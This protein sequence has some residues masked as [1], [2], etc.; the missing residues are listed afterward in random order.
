[1]TVKCEKCGA[2]VELLDGAKSA[3]CEKCGAEV[4]VKEEAAA[5]ATEEKKEEAAEATAEATEEKKEEA[6]EK[7]PLTPKEKAIKYSI[8]VVE[9]AVIL[10]ALIWG[11]PRVSVRLHQ[12]RMDSIG[13]P[14]AGDNNRQLLE[15]K[16]VDAETVV[17]PGCFT[18]IGK[19][20]FIDCKK[21]KSITIP[22]TVKEI[23]LKAFENIETLE[24][25]KISGGAGAYSLLNF[26]TYLVLGKDSTAAVIEKEAFSGCKKLKSIDLPE[27]LTSIGQS[28]FADCKALKEIKLPNTVTNIAPQAF[29]RSGLKKVTIPDSVQ[30][31]GTMAFKY[32]D[33][34]EISVPKKFTDAQITAWGIDP[35]KCKIVKR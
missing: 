1:M 18:S 3:K 12:H 10:F 24:E 13:M 27:G 16:N 25:V 33:L 23:G 11:V 8:L 22:A 26:A 29:I 35:E 14:L 30:T 17:L 31:I 7:K 32:A 34:E 5:E 4:T 6:A 20:A 19:D 28:A 21:L 9:I 2:D 15:Y